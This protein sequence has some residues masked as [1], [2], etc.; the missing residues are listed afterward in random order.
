M[1]SWTQIW[2]RIRNPDPGGTPLNP[3]PI[4]VQIY[5]TA[6][7][8]FLLRDPLTKLNP[9]SIQIQMHKKYHEEPRTK[10]LKKGWQ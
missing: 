1:P 4:R 5:N 9:N 3:D 7:F 6:L 10:M 8:G 2:I